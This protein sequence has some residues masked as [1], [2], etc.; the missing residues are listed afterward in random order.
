M[1]AFVMSAFVMSSST[2]ALSNENTTI[3]LLSYLLQ[4]GTEDILHA[5]AGN[6]VTLA[7]DAG[8]AL[9]RAVLSHWEEGLDPAR[10]KIMVTLSARSALDLWLQAKR[11][12]PGSRVLMTAVNIPDVLRLL[13]AHGLVPVP[14]DFCART[15]QPKL[16]SLRAAIRLQEQPGRENEPKA[17][18]LL[19]AHL[20]GRRVRMDSAAA[21]AKAHGLCLVEDMAEAFAG[22]SAA[23]RGGHP[24]S[25][26]VFWSFGTIKTSTAFGGGVCLIREENTSNAQKLF[27]EMQEIHDIYPVQSRLT[28]LAKISKGSLVTGM[29]NWTPFTRTAQNLA[30]RSNVDAWGKVVHLVRGFSGSDLIRAIRHRPCAPLLYLLDQRF[31][32]FEHARDIQAATAVCDRFT[33]QLPVVAGLSIPGDQ[34][35]TRNYWLYPLILPADWNKDEFLIAC[36]D[37]GL[38]VA[39]TSSQLAAVP[40][41]REIGRKLSPDPTEAW[42]MFERIIYV[43]MH[44]L[45]SSEQLFAATR[46]MEDVCVAFTQSRANL[47]LLM[48]S[49]SQVRDQADQQIESAVTTATSSS[50]TAT[51]TTATPITTATA[52]SSV[53]AIAG[54]SVRARVGGDEWEVLYYDENEFFLFLL[55]NESI[56]LC[57]TLIC[58]K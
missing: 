41:P 58:S 35:Q 34:A 53:A 54:I 10:E 52:A 49:R 4:Q 38:M 5:H 16:S 30:W 18:M 28:Y 44:K 37:R 12:R 36:R 25:S 19:V 50:S 56:I 13:R 40:H 55:Y 3:I 42:S 26:L 20:W 39:A 32:R 2:L 31:K 1:I 9:E 24:V 7:P 17:V 48:K 45:V 8:P 29:L 33:A 46:T 11:F 43:P 21:F 22:C 57:V 23:Q 15:L 14:I 51:T 27:S 6:L 47:R